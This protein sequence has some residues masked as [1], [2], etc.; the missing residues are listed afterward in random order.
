MRTVSIDGPGALP[1]GISS[2]TYNITDSRGA[3]AGARVALSNSDNSF[4]TVGTTSSDGLVTFD[5]AEAGQFTQNL[6]IS[7]S[8]KNTALTES[9]LSI[10]PAEEPYLSMTKWTVNGRTEN[11]LHV[12]EHAVFGF[13][14]ANLGNKP[15]RGGTF[16]IET[17][18]GPAAILTRSFNIPAIPAGGVTVIASSGLGIKV[19]ESAT[20][21]SSI[22]L[23]MKWTTG[24]G[25]SAQT[26]NS[27]E[28]VRAAVE[29]TAV[30]FGSQ[31]TNQGGIRPGETGSVYLTIKNTGS[32]TISSGS[33]TPAKGAC[34][35]DVTG[36]AQI[37][38]LEPGASLRLASPLAVSV[39]SA[40]KSGDLAALTVQGTY[41]SI[42]GLIP[43]NTSASFTAGVL[44]DE[45]KS[46]DDA[47][48]A[49]PDKASIT[50][51]IPFEAEG[52]ITQ[53]GLLLDVA[54][55]YIGDLKISLVH[56]DGTSAVVW[57]RAGG[58]ADQIQQTFG[59]GG[60]DMPD[61]A[62]F[63]GKP[64][65]GNWQLILSDEA[66][67]DTGILNRVQL[68]VRGYLN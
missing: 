17:V 50:Q 11:K 12:N 31:D 47:A 58:S 62:A 35:A 30:D 32:E 27:F 59:I 37:L 42:A 55:T 53:I 28:V 60:T 44:T 54:H 48:L 10:I 40:C 9:N 33:L 68:T 26:A 22:R 8:G 41:G 34:V 1:V 19:S 56:P 20:S 14:L 43:L 38:N 25:Q 66:A 2:A 24:E 63:A 4:M 6:K 18:E 57:S 23:R 39:D 52:S 65:Q 64:S 29:V 61:F 51:V 7:V 45:T 21:N 13:K 36:T 67:S 5:L 16:I 3:V 46:I 49:I 15:T